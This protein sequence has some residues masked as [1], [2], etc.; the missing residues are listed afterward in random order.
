MVLAAALVAIAAASPLAVTESALSIP[1]AALVDRAPLDGIPDGWTWSG[2]KGRVRVSPVPG[3]GGSTAAKLNYEAETKGQLCSG[4]AAV[5]PGRTVVV[6]GAVRGEPSLSD[7]TA[8]HLHLG[9]ERPSG[10]GTSRASGVVAKRRFDKGDY[11]WEPIEITA[12][13]PAGA[14]RAW[15]CVEVAIVPG[16]KAGAA[17]LGPLSVAERAA[18]SRGEALSPRRVIMVT[19][20]TFRRDHVHAY[21][22]PRATTPVLDRLIAE[23]TSFDRHR[24]QAPYTHPSLASLL[25][26]LLP[27]QLGFADNR[28]VATLLARS[29]AETMAAAGYVT[30]A[31]SSQYV[32]SN[33]YGLNRGFHYYRNHPNDTP[34]N[35]LHLELMP[36][37]DEHAEDNLFLWLH[38][39]EPHGPYRPP[40]P[41]R[42]KFTGDPT[43]ASD[44][45]VLRHS[46]DTAEGVPLI[47]NY[48]Y[49]KE[50]FERRHYVA[51]YDGDIAWLDQSLGQLVQF[52]RERGWERDTLLLVTGDH[53]ESMTEHARFFCHGS[54]Y[55]HDLH[56]PFVAWGAGVPAGRRVDARTHHVDVA[57]T[58]AALVGQPAP[59]ATAGRSFLG[60]LRGG[61]H[62]PAPLSIAMRGKDDKLRFAVVGDA[63]I[64]LVV[65]AAGTAYEAYDLVQDPGETQNFAGLRPAVVGPVVAQFKEWLRTSGALAAP[66]PEQALDPEDVEML[67]ALGYIQ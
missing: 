39:F 53:G 9:N 57:P 29:L 24:V 56:V 4:S 17:W 51:G 59:V 67:R 2:S 7:V 14:D 27:G 34:A 31:W 8:L 46:A 38:Y 44:P 16:G 35:A 20:E 25:T 43:W 58:L 48:V 18:T 22:Y 15:M 49:D 61:A 63:G 42:A 60:S 23:G 1:N 13:V 30:A 50:Q 10:S 19:V 37:L 6:T 54:L 45:A 32:L 5:T 21:G 52:V 12:T 11:P 3:P 55:E 40:A 62:Q 64:K 28:P 36:F 47:P 41:L 66:Q 33:R 26:G 65:D